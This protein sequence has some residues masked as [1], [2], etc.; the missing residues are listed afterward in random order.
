MNDA[1]HGSQWS[2]ARMF[3]AASAVFHI[4]GAVAGFAVDRSFPVGAAAAART[5]PA[6]IF[7][8]FE[9]NGWH[10][11][12]ALIVGLVSLYYALCSDHARDAAIT[13]GVTHV[14]LV[15]AL[16]GWEP[17]TFWL[18]SNMADQIVHATTAVGGTAAG[19]LTRRRAHTTA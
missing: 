13:L 3:L 9:T 14:G 5:P 2:P 16:V 11:L 7:G 19:L 10:T 12:G 18:A 17:S 15:F 1:T 8:V 6:L 4:P